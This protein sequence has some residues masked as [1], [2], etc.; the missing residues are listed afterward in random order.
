MRHKVSNVRYTKG[1][2]GVGDTGTDR[3]RA[4]GF[5][6]HVHIFSK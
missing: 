2:H 6:I 4:G 3:G 5:Y 1:L